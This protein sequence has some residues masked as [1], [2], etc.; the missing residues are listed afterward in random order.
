[1]YQHPKYVT[2]MYPLIPFIGDWLENRRVKS[3]PPPYQLNLPRS[4][5]LGVIKLVLPT[6]PPVVILLV[7]PAPSL[8]VNVLVLPTPCLVVKLL[9]VPT[10]LLDIIL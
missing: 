9:V 2:K 3:R 1:M 8:V 5:P 10:L 4:W 7:F 6:P